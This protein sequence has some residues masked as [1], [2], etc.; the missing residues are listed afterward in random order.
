MTID[1]VDSYNQD[2]ASLDLFAAK[3]YQKAEAAQ[4][5][6]YFES[7]IVPVIVEGKAVTKD[8]G[9]RPGVT[10]EVKFNC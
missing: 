6:G 10:P 5:A 9:I 7:E 8:D 1:L 3:S 4:K 2:R